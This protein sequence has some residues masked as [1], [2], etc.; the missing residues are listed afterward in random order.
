MLFLQFQRVKLAQIC[1][2]CLP[3][4]EETTYSSSVSSAPFRRC[5]YR[6]LGVS[7]VCFIF[8]DYFEPR[9]FYQSVKEEF[10]HHG[11]EELPKYVIDHFEKDNIR[12][13]KGVPIPLFPNVN[14]EY[15]YDAYEKDIAIA[16]FYFEKPTITQF[17]R[18]QRMTVFDFLSQV[19]ILSYS[20]T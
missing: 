4:C 16:H 17:E 6:S 12:E 3:D 13:L 15:S 19:N 5:D 18:S 1:D 9:S 2:H 14:K 11:Y 8:D 20:T 10:K 7:D